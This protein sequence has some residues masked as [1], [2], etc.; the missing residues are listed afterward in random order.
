MGITRRVRL[1]SKGQLVIPQE[2]RERLGLHAGD[3][4]VLHLLS[5]RLVLAEV[6]P[7]S[8]FEEAVAG[9]RAEAEHRGITPAEVEEAL[10]EARREVYGEGAA[11][12]VD[13]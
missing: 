11:R 13:P 4:L 9:L 1:S 10:A 3:E 12:S 6:P 7:R 2:L 5:D 8:P